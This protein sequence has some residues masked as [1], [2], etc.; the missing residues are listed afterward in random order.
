MFQHAPACSRSWAHSCGWARAPPFP[1]WKEIRGLQMVTRT[2]GAHTPRGQDLEGPA[3]VCAGSLDDRASLGC[4]G[5]NG[6]ARP[7]SSPSWLSRPTPSRHLPPLHRHFSGTFWVPLAC[8]QVTGMDEG[9][10]ALTA[11]ETHSHSASGAFGRGPLHPSK[12]AA[13][14]TGLADGALRGRHPPLLLHVLSRNL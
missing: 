10:H 13:P 2:T 12:P 9:S 3:W 6:T 8:A 1:L 5:G 14:S 11:L 4:A 7:R